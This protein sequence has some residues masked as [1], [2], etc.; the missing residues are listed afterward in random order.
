[1]PYRSFRVT[2]KD[3]LSQLIILMT[4]L[5]L[6]ISAIS[7][8]CLGIENV[9]E[10][11]NVFVALSWLALSAAAFYLC[12]LRHGYKILRM[13]GQK[14]RD[15]IARSLFLNIRSGGIHLFSIFLRPVLYY[16]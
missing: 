15:E 1:M 4:L 5:A 8:I 16:R 10:G 9:H 6:L 2:S 7:A 12:S 11:G 14:R 13:A 3:Q